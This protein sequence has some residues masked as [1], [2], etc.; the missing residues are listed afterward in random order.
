MTGSATFNVGAAE[1]PPP[2]KRHLVDLAFEA[3][4][5]AIA[6]L[7][8][9]STEVVLLDLPRGPIKSPK[10]LRKLISASRY[11]LSLLAPRQPPQRQNIPHILHLPRVTGL[12]TCRLTPQGR[13]LQAALRFL[14]LRQ[15]PG[16]ILLQ[17]TLINLQTAKSSICHVSRADG[18]GHVGFKA[19]KGNQVKVLNSAI[20]GITLAC[21]PAHAQQGPV[22]TQCSSDI[23]RHCDGLSHVRGA[24][25]LCLEENVSQVSPE[26]LTA[27]E[28][29]GPR[30]GRQ[31]QSGLSQRQGNM[32]PRQILDS[33]TD[34]GYTNLRQIEREGGQYEVEATDAEGQNVE[35]YID[36]ET[37]EVL[38]LERED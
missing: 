33:L 25:R 19:G 37:G 28:A 21:S 12:T 5:Q 16:S 20:L 10:Q 1:P 29:A 7:Q 15:C 3:P 34:L 9:P 11:P 26:C 14:P 6:A 31:M 30:S 36:A 35:I 38:R 18:P 8:R 24:V 22:A 32:G 17:L 13:A 4:E 23:A 2:G 27:L